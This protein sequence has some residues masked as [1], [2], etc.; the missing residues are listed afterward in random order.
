VVSMTPRQSTLF[1]GQAAIFR[2]CNFSGL[3]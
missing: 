3:R 2:L 1:S